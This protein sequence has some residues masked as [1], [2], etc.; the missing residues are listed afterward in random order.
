MK[1]ILCISNFIVIIIIFLILYYY[2]IF[3]PI[4]NIELVK[5]IKG[6]PPVSF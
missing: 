3:F 6:N 5:P 4:E 1:I 2:Y